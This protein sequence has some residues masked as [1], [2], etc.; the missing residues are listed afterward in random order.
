VVRMATAYSGTTTPQPRKLPAVSTR[1]LRVC[2]SR[3]RED[4]RGKERC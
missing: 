2:C 1:S 3:G 4:S